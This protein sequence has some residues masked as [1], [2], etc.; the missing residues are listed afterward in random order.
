MMVGDEGWKGSSICCL[1]YCH[2]RGRDGG[3]GRLKEGFRGLEEDD[4]GKWCKR[5][6]RELEKGSGTY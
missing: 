1:E 6:G 5:S 4:H 3:E 2:Q